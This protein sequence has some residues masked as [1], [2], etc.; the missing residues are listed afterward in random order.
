MPA[1]TPSARAPERRR[2]VGVA[3]IAVALIALATVLLSL[4]QLER[5]RAGLEIRD[6]VSGTTPATLYRRPDAEG[7]LVVVAHGFAGSRQLMQAFSLT[8]ARSGYVVL[9]FDF[10][11]HGRNPV[12]MSGDVGSID[13]TTALLVEETRRVIAT[14]RDLPGVAGGVALLGH[15]M[16]TDVIVRAAAAERAAGAS[17][18]AVV[19]I[20]MYSDAVTATAPDRLLVITG[21]WEG[22]LRTAAL[23]ALRMV[24]PDA[25]E[26]ESVARGDVVRRAVVAPGVEHVGVLFSGTAL[27]EARAFLDMAFGRNSD[28]DT[29]RPGP[30]ILSLLAGI[31]ALLRPVCA[32]L[33][34][35]DRAPAE[36]PEWRFWAALAIPAAAVPLVCTVLYVPVLPVLVADY[37]MLHMAAYGVLQLMLIGIRR[38]GWRGPSVPAVLLLATW[39]IAVFGIAMDRYGASFMPNFE[40]LGIVAALAVGT[41]PFMVADAYLTGSGRGRWWRR[42]AARL[43]L[44]A[45]LI[46]AA[47]LDPERLGF[48]LIVLPVLIL[49]FLV[50]GLMG[51]WIARR[52]GPM[53]AG[54]GLGLCLAWAL[55]VSFPLFAA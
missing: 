6:L 47:L 10:Q 19:A 32:L 33:P 2:R 12:P 21:Q 53:S 49:F 54:I 34:P 18:A 51:R 30:W 55:G 43:G 39:G 27:R 9:G 13:G 22:R 7:P 26:G 38:G 40:R 48:V 11:G 46:G 24:A 4:V 29:V 45:S 3:D 36:I 15:S 44:A 1:M 37:L 8:L 41:V 5:G 17:V 31:V 35:R 20:S 14:G 23:D 50:H 42:V 16:A 28:G 25:Q 52:S